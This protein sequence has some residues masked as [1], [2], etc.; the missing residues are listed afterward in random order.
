[1]FVKQVTPQDAFE[2]LKKDQNAV[3][4]DVRAFEE[5]NFVGFVNPSDFGNRM[6]L[7]PWQLYPEMTENPDFAAS[8]ADSL[9]QLGLED[10]GQTRIF[11][12][13][14]TGGRSDAAAHFALN[15]G[16]KNCYN[17]MF[18]FEGELNAGIHRGQ[19]NGWKASS[20]PWRQK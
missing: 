11:F 16:Y 4:V 12:L 6:I 13:C 18:G 8:L 2:E 15:A 5:F 14:R 3:L 19:V 1:M 9:N 17:I 7:L 10:N 20:L